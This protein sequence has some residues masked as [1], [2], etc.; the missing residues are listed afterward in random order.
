MRGFLIETGSREG[1]IIGGNLQDA[2]KL[3]EGIRRV[4]IDYDG[5]VTLSGK[6]LKFAIADVQEKK[7][8][9]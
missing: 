7:E 6:A 2:M 5:N 4:D 8:E 9:E 3:I 1:I